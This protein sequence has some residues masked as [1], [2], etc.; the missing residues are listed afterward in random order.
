MLQLKHTDGRISGIAYA[1][2]FSD[3]SFFNK[4]FKKQWE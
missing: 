4:L 2:G 1:G 3:L